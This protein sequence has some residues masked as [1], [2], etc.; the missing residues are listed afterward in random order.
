MPRLVVIS[1]RV[2]VPD[3]THPAAP[4]GLAVAVEAAMRQRDGIWF[5]WSGEKAEEPGPLTIAQRGNLTYILTDLHP[6]DFDEYYN[7]FANRVL[8]PILHYRVDLAEFS[9]ADFDGYRR[10]NEFFAERLSPLLEPDD[11][12][13]VHD[14]HLIPLAL[15]LRARGHANRIGFF[16]HIPMPPADLLTAMPHHAELIRALTEYNLIGFQ[17]E[18]DASNFSRYLTRVV[19]AATPDGRR[20]HLEG[21]H[22]RVGVFPVGVDAEGFRQ[23][24]ERAERSQA[25]E[26]LRES[27]GG[28]ALMVGVDRLD[29]SK[30]IVNRLD[31]YERFLERFP[32]WHNRVTCLQISP[33]S[34]QDIPE[35]ADIEAAVSARVGH[36]NGRFGAVSWV[37]LR[38]VGRN[39]SRED[40][41]M[42]MRQARIGLVTP[43]R[44]G[45]NLVAKEFVAAQDLDDPGVLILS[46]FA[47]AA[48]ELDGA[49]IIN[50]HDRDALASAID[51]ALRMPLGERK[52]RHRDMFAVLQANDIRFWGPSFIEALTR[53]GRTLNWLSSH[54]LSH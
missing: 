16:L 4:G 29:Y 41:A 39:H 15:A 19:G 48:A 12:L 23:L 20:Y 45:M 17:T 46:Q 50:P 37:P 54:A 1:N 49:L 33:G 7:G 52:A 32:E 11:V 18:N 30:G 26:D 42:V 21:Q 43:L 13:W 36:I 53:P 27:L 6:Q 38:Y 2:V 28:R 22:F 34:R 40:I 8:W 10:V 5:G 47:G 31:G 35:Y 14:Y 9:E 24:A 25:A 3:D 44:D 51:T